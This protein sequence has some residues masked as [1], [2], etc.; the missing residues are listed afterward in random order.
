MI[1]ETVEEREG[2]IHKLRALVGPSYKLHL[3]YS[4]GSSEIVPALF[5]SLSS[6]NLYLDKIQD[7]LID[8]RLLQTPLGWAGALWGMEV[9]ARYINGLLVADEGEN[10]SIYS[11]Q[12]KKVQKTDAIPSLSF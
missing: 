1:G 4:D 7:Q 12:S 2:I 11:V 3:H 5:C 8:V 10:R 6:K 9:V